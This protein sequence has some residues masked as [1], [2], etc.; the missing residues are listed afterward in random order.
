[1]ARRR[2]TSQE[3]DAGQRE[4]RAPQA[5]ARVGQGRADDGGEGRADQHPEPGRQREML[6]QQRRRVGADAVEHRVAEGELP[7]EAA[8][9]VPRARQR[10]VDADDDEDVGD[11]RGAARDRHDQQEGER[12]SGDVGAG[13]R[14][15]PQAR[16]AGP[17]GRGRGLGVDG[18]GGAERLEV[19]LH[20]A[21]TPTRA[22]AEQ[23]R[24][25]HDQD[26]EE[27]D[28]VDDL[29]Q[30]GP[31]V[32]AAQ[33]LHDADDHRADHGAVEAAHP[34]QHDHD[35]GGE[36][37]IGPDRRERRIDG[38]EERRRRRR[39]RCRCRR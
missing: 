8:D 32:V 2:S 26:D 38:R 25:A 21:I 10:G 16:S 18:L 29:L 39:R 36:H 1:M 35:E 22:R 19:R 9:D 23:P 28:E 31:D 13:L 4:E 34:A 17:R 12:Q 20:R 33:P 37:E 11:E 6:H 5:Q 3:G 7:T 14:Q 24:R 27:Q 15:P 30:V